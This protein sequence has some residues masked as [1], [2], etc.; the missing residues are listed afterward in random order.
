MHSAVMRL[1]QNR[2][3]N[4]KMELID[5]SWPL[6]AHTTGYKNDKA[7]NIVTEKTMEQDNVRNS[8]ITLSAHAGT[9]IDAPAHFLPDGNTIEK[10]PLERYV[11]L[12]VVL[13]LT[14]L[15]NNT[16][17]KEDLM[18]YDDMILADGFILLKTSNSALSYDAPF[19]PHFTYLSEMGATYLV[20]KKVRGVA[21]DY[22]GIERE[23]RAHQTHTTLMNAGII[24]V[25]GVRLGHV[26]QGAYTFACF[27]LAL[28]GTEASPAR[29]L[30][31]R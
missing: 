15:S 31:I 30:L 12:G 2:R 14:H 29:A 24:I 20:E 8:R 25:E 28:N 19:D 17:T 22:L 18:S 16:I 10:I 4:N 7:V 6:D 23:Q 27:P 9:H 1:I 11:A 21:I 26:D 5:I 13:D 3:D